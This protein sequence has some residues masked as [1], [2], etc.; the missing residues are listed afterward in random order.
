MAVIIV[1]VMPAVKYAMY[2]VIGLGVLF[3]LAILCTLLYYRKHKVRP[4]ATSCPP[5]VHLAENHRG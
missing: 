4:L 1:T 3:L 5:H 2:G